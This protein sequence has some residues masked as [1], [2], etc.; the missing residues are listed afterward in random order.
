MTR[1][2]WQS[3][4]LL[5]AL[6]ALAACSGAAPEAESTLVEV[7]S[8]TPIPPTSS[9]PP[10]ATPFPT[11]TASLTPT[12]QPSLTATPEPTSTPSPT[13]TPAPTQTP[14]PEVV[15]AEGQ[16]L[17][18]MT[19]GTETISAAIPEYALPILSAGGTESVE[20]EEGVQTG[21][22]WMDDNT[23]YLGKRN[24]DKSTPIF[25]RD[26]NGQWEFNG[27]FVPEENYINTGGSAL[28][29]PDTQIIT[30]DPPATYPFTGMLVSEHSGFNTMSLEGAPRE[31]KISEVLLLYQG[32]LIKTQKADVLIEFLN[33]N[34][35]AITSI[36]APVYGEISVNNN[37]GGSFNL[38]SGR[39]S[40][41]FS[42]TT[43]RKTE[44]M[45]IILRG[46][47]LPDLDILTLR[48]LIISGGELPFNTFMTS[49]IDNQ[50]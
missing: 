7:P 28:V 49:F 26:A 31:V 2:W 41:S 6:F 43:S 47:A 35:Q 38:L 3:T 16:V 30:N 17:F 40:G 22:Y 1:H 11:E 9:P 21:M 42:F 44:T 37:R 4:I 25:T 34:T 39:D 23:V 10:S 14:T 12:P 19:L 32:N 48:S 27:N 18:Q 29:L 50:G 8:T 20:I 33:P 5:F 24:G 15:V 13:D 36:V 46:G 45:R